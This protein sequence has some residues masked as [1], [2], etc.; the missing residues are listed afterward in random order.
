[1]A[2]GSVKP[3]GDPRG[4]FQAGMPTGIARRRDERLTQY[5]LSREP[6]LPRKIHYQR[7]CFL[8]YDFLNTAPAYLAILRQ[9][10]VYHHERPIVTS[11]L[12]ENL[13][14]ALVCPKCG[15]NKVRRATRLFWERALMLLRVRPFRCNRCYHRFYARTKMLDKS[16][17]REAV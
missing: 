1:M 9:R 5:F 10:R 12:V 17:S 16:P 11:A 4:L 2:A 13:Q 7:D 3:P 6:G 14:L 15:G 8:C